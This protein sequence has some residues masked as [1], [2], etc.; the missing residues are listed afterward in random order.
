MLIRAVL[1]VMDHTRVA[2]ILKAEEGAP[3]LVERIAAGQRIVF[4]ANHADYAA[5]TSGSAGRRAC[6]RLRPRH[7]LPAEHVADGGLG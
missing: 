2:A 7:A 4:F 6:T 3:P 1:S 5:V